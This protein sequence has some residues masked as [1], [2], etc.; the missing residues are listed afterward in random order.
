MNP[1]V[2]ILQET[3][4]KIS[5]FLMSILRDLETEEAELHIING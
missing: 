4:H 1:I 3:L 5:L 2:T